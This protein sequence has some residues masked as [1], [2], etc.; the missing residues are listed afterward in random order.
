[1][2]EFGGKRQ[3]ISISAFNNG[4]SQ[5]TAMDETYYN[6]NPIVVNYRKTNQG[7]NKSTLGQNPTSVND[8]MRQSR[9]SMSNNEDAQRPAN[10]GGRSIAKFK[11]IRAGVYA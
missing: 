10:T 1:V 5:R 2:D 8:K 3:D 11:Q 4:R 9:M 7:F 6:N